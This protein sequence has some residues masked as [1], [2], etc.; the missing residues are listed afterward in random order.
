[1]INPPSSDGHKWVLTTTDY[2]TRWTEAVALKESNE[3]A[4][5]D[6]LEGIMMRF[7][8]PFTVISAN[9]LAFLG[10]KLSEWAVKN[11]VYLKTSSNYYP[12]GNGLAESSNKNLIRIIKRTMETNKRTWHTQLK[13]ALWED[14]ITPKRA[15]GNSPFVLVY[16]REE[17][18]PLSLELP[19]LELAHQLEVIE[20]DPL[21]I[22]F[23][24]L[25][26]LEE[27]RDKAMKTLEQHQAQVKKSFDKKASDKHFQEGD[28]V[29]KW[30][31]DRAKPGRHAKFDALWSG[32]YIITSCKEAN[33]FHLSRLNGEELPIHVNGIHLKAY[34]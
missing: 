29:L 16:G 23:A 31:E 1:M 12:Q 6:F 27:V 7:G 8:V 18:L 17:K 33:S 13:T 21:T 32:A 19:S 15:I 24:E 5:L 11:G 10:M 14:R 4:V 3:K 9:A 30:D 25:M 26:E 20:S 28:L 2:F 34:F 22:R